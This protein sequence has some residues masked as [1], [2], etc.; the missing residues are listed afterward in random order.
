VLVADDNADMRIYL[1]RLLAAYEVEVWQAREQAA[2]ILECVTDGFVAMDGEWRFTHAN[3]QTVRINGTRR[4]DQIGKTR[5][6]LFPATRATIP[7]FEWRRA[8][9]EHVAVQLESYFQPWD[10][11]FQN[12]AYPRKD[13]GLSVFSHIITG[14][15]RSEEALRKA[16]NQL[17]QRIGE[18]TRELSRTNARLKRQVAKRKQVEEARSDLLRR[19]VHAQEVEHRRIARELHDDLTQRLAV[20]AIDAGSLEQLPGCPP[21]VGRR[22][23]VMRDEL[24][25]LSES[26]HSLS[27]QL[28]PSILDDLG[29][30]DALRSECLSVYQR[31]GVSVEYYPRDVPTNLRRDVALCVYRVAQEALRN[32]ARHARTPRASVRLVAT[33]R[34]LVLSVRDRGVG[35]EVAARGRAGVGLESM[36][37]RAR[38][39]QARL[40]VRSRAGK[41][42][43]VTLRV[44][45][46]RSQP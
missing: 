12:K 32:V 29:L 9:A 40:T 31:D 16:H 39:I 6:E 2:A 21:D 1:G 10:A 25:A 41:G 8:V 3:V 20:L 46:H 22:A 35:F 44:P 24:V 14:R 45:L 19:L 5:W 13:E 26:V 27:R 7:G 30:T 43:K 4:E 28:H 36:R 17:E 42:T 34:E 11:R 33:G 38:L 23:G 18:R 37:E 15:K